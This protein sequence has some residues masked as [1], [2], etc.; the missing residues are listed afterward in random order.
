MV[1]DVRIFQTEHSVAVAAHLLGTDKDPCS[2]TGLAVSYD[3]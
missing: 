1:T 3:Y 2:N